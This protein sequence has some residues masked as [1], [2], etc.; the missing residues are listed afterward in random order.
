MFNDKVFKMLKFVCSLVLV[1]SFLNSFGQGDPYYINSFRFSQSQVHGSAR[2]LGFAGAQTALGADLGALS[3]N[4]AGLGFYRKS[5]FSFAPNFSVVKTNSETQ[6]FSIP[7]NKIV[8]NVNNL[9]IAFC[10]LRDDIVESKWRG[11]TFAIG[12]TRTTNFQNTTTYKGVTNNSLADYVRD[13]ANNPNQPYL[14]RNYNKNN[15]NGLVDLAYGAYLFSPVYDPRNT[16]SLSN[17]VYRT[18]QPPVNQYGET[19]YG[20]Q[21][22]INESGG[23][24]EWSAGY[25]GNY[26]NKLFFGASLSYVRLRYDRTNSYHE[27]ALNNLD[28]SNITTDITLNETLKVRGSGINL[29]IGA[30][31]V[32]NDII[33]VGASVKTPTYM[34]I[35]ETYNANMSA[36]Y[37]NLNRD[38]DGQPGS[39]DKSSNTSINKYSLTSPLTLSGGVALFAGKRGFLTAD[40][41]YLDYTSSF[42]GGKDKTLYINSNQLTKSY[43][44]SVINYRIGAEVRADIMRFRL[45]YALYSSPWNSEI[46]DTDRRV[47]SSD[48]NVLTLGLG[49]R[50]E[51]FFFDLAIG[52]TFYDSDYVPYINNPSDNLQVKTS[53]VLNNITIGGGFFF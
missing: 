11:G 50:T 23:T 24:N 16:D 41:E 36:N 48:M 43:Y 20:K 12:L 26:N 46:K 33:R 6:G 29:T 7:D 49:V 27:Y 28:V 51:E 5:E 42:I 3:S 15:V 39:G 52:H 34:S 38:F 47:R 17:S 32:F 10:H 22:T 18:L 37:A 1:L 25:G 45:G 30:N 44:Q 21:E 9:G 31:Y 40:I 13:I 14:W 19:Q 2:S 53:N 4:P 35:K 8:L